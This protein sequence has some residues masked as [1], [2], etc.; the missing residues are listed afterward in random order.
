MPIDSPLQAVLEL[1][2]RL[3]FVLSDLNTD[4]DYETRLLI[5]Q[6]LDRTQHIGVYASALKGD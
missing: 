5:E 2:N 4:L 1:R 6:S 3:Q